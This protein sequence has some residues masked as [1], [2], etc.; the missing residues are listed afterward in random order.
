M[1]KTIYLMAIVGLLVANIV[2][3]SKIRSSQLVLKE[4]ELS[5]RLHQLQSQQRIS[6]YEDLLLHQTKQYQDQFQ[7]PKDLQRMIR[8]LVGDKYD[9]VLIYR[10]PNNVCSSCVLEDL[11]LMKKFKEQVDIIPVV[12]VTFEDTRNEHI[13]ISNEL[14]DVTYFRVPQ[15]D[16]NLT[17]GAKE[18]ERF[19]W[20]DGF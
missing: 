4:C 3:I 18:V 12:L 16:L 10:Y 7:I 11:D 1:K 6:E 13:R 8:D 20:K 2:F 19:F 14:Q 17:Q 15:E 5:A 9:E